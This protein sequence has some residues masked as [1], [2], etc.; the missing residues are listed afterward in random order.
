VQQ[1]GLIATL[2]R[3]KLEVRDETWI[4]GAVK[5][6]A[7]FCRISEQI[8]VGPPK[9]ASEPK[10]EDEYGGIKRIKTNMNEDEVEEIWKLGPDAHVTN[11]F[12]FAKVRNGG[13]NSDDEDLDKIDRVRE[14]LGV[15]LGETPPSTPGEG[16]G[17]AE[18]KKPEP[19]AQP[20]QEPALPLGMLLKFMSTGDADLQ[21]AIHS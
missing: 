14:E 13:E 8:D 7:E 9:A 17:E 19:P 16:E 18:V 1:G 10:D 15:E 6:A 12:F 5:K 2:T 4:D 20:L 21:A 3:K 11:E